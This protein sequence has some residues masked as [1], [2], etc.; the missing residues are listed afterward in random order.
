MISLALKYV[1]EGKFDLAI[2]QLKIF[3][4][5]NNYQY[6]ILLFFVKDPLMNKLKN[7]P[8]Y[9]PILQKIKNQFWENQTQLKHS[10][11]ET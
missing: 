11:E 10:L 6:W 5:K 7:H 9:D 3:A 1:H 8:E 2:E 4:S